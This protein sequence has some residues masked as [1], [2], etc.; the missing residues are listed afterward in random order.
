MPQASR[1]SFR[2]L[3]G[4]TALITGA[5]SGIGAEFARQLAARGCPL[6]LVA[7]RGEVLERTAA[8]L[9]ARYGVACETL[10]ADLST[11][12]GVEHVCERL[13]DDARPVDIL[14][15]N[16][17]SGLHATSLAEDVAEHE[18]AFDLMVRAVFLLANAAGRAMRQRDRGLI[19]N[20]ASVASF[21]NM[22]N[23]SAIK[24]WVRRWSL[25]L[26]NELHGTG[27]QVMTLNPG[28]VRTEFHERAGIRTSN[29]PSFLWIDVT[30]LVAA[31]LADVDKG[32]IISIPSLRFKTL[33]FAAHHGPRKAVDAVVRSI[34]RGRGK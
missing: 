12:E 2:R 21:V 24:A 20:I 5:T 17:G 27:V 22:G 18:Q 28:W 32:R 14:V 23:Y 3:D 13:L 11:T 7:R 29:I 33:A 26:A 6:V 1:S 34:N 4:G 25:S 8:D 9:T 19:I 31:C 16:A 10:V 15:N 30:E